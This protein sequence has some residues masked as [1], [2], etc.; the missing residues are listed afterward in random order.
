M[1]DIK[2]ADI[3]QTRFYQEVFQEG[4]QEGLQEGL[5]E[6]RQEGAQ[7]G[8]ATIIL[9]LLE[10]NL[11]TLPE[12]QVAQIRALSLVQL[13]ALWEALFNFADQSALDAWL[14]AQAVDQVSED[15][16]EGI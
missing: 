14:Q 4:Q 9:R 7:Q 11:G 6:G 8:E 5:Q 13:D 12:A 1:L 15:V 16:E 2:T 3:R 10:R